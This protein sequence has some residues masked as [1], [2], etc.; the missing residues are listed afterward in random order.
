MFYRTEDEGGGGP[1]DEETQTVDEPESDA[2][3]SEDS[4]DS[5]IDR[6]GDNMSYLGDLG[7]QYGDHE[8]PS[9]PYGLSLGADEY[10]DRIDKM[11]DEVD[12]YS[13]RD[14]YDGQMDFAQ[15]DIP[16]GGETGAPKLGPEIPE[17]RQ[18]PIEF[19]CTIP[20]GPYQLRFSTGENGTTIGGQFDMGV[21]IGRIE[22][23]VHVGVDFNLTNPEKSRIVEGVTIPFAGTYEIGLSYEEVRDGI[24]DY[25]DQAYREA[26]RQLNFPDPAGTNLRNQY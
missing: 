6:P 15:K 13:P 11:Q 8:P 17:P 25:A 20:I 14:Y 12:R 22:V 16:L 2:E 4:T 9:N 7:V 18:A 19:D 1:T 24:V 3:E 26:L 5:Q 23:D 10:I 21:K